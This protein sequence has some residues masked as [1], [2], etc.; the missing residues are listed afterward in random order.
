MQEL[1]EKNHVS[2]AELETL[3]KA[4]EEGKVDFLLIDVREDM[5]YNMGHIKGVDMLRP[6]STFQQWAQEIFDSYKDKTIIFTCR[7]DNRSGQVQQ[8]FAQ[9]GHSKTLNHIG[10]IVSYRGEIEK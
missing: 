6:T 2:S 9:N 4:R 1:L 8:V 3:L 10:G 7:T 5:E